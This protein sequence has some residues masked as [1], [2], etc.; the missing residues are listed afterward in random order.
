MF[1]EAVCGELTRL[2]ARTALTTATFPAGTMYSRVA[3]PP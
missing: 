2:A 1:R 3:A